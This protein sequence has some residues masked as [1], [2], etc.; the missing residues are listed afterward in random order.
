MNRWTTRGRR[1][2]AVLLVA[3]TAAAC[4]S[5]D[6]VT[7]PTTGNTTPIV[8]TYAGTL[9]KNGAASYPFAT[10]AG[11]VQAT[12]TSVSP[13]NTITIG[14]ALGTWNG[15][16]CTVVLANDKALQG[17]AVVGTVNTTGS[18][19]VRVYDVGNV[20]DPLTYE[21]RVQHL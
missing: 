3:G 9:T 7:S 18:L 13:D 10:L 17:T 1:I 19:C 21:V 15:V 2:F 11:S 12:L 6:L 8:E 14:L 20:G 4:S 16:S 5:N